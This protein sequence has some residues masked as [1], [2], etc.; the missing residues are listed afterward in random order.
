MRRAGPALLAAL[1]GALAGACSRAGDETA[2]ARPRNAVLIVVDTLRANRLG[3]YGYPRPTSPHVD[4]LAA[5]GTLYRNNRSQGCWT[6]PSMISLMGGHYVTQTERSLPRSIPVLAEALQAGGI[7]TAAFVGNPVLTGD[8]GFQRGFD[9]FEGAKPNGRAVTLAKN[10]RRWYQQNRRELREGP[11]FFAWVHP[12]DPHHPYAP[13]AEHRVFHGRRPD[14]DVLIERY[15]AEEPRVAELS[16][17]VEP[18]SLPAAAAEMGELS[19]LYDGEVLAVDEGVRLLLDCLRDEDELART[20]VIFA[21]DHGEMLWEHPH[22]PLEVS[23]RIQKFGGL[24][25]GV[26]DLMAFGHRAWFHEDLWNTPLILSGPGIPAGMRRE[27]LSANLDIY[28]T[29]LDAFDVP[30][31]E[32]L[33]SLP[34]QSL[35]GGVEPDREQVF[36]YGFDT[37]AALERSGL[38]LIEHNRG[39]FLLEGEGE[40]PLELFDLRAN[41]GETENLAETR[42]ADAHRLEA[43]IAAWRAANAREVET[44]TSEEDEAILRDLGYVDSTLEEGAT[45]PD[46]AG[47]GTPAGGSDAGREGS[48]D[49]R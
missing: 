14:A 1:L 10:F 42:S 16:P 11:G 3:C 21:A 24:P 45:A 2:A 13:L 18:L 31:P 33:D 6:V 41:P 15:R 19:N 23:L 7:T 46:G 29:L 32:G 30:L 25:D 28:P 9:H 34:G 17:D 36:G 22:Y 4:R 5:T 26:K 37:T 12:M 43:A 48:G 27:G 47:A 35:L 44:A 8:R 39:R 49:S 20:L 40:R 38:K